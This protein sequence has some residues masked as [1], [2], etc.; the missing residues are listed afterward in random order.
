[1]FSFLVF[2]GFVAGP[3][4]ADL[5]EAGKCIQPDGQFVYGPE[6][7]AADVKA[8]ITIS[9]GHNIQIHS[10]TG[11]PLKKP[12]NQGGGVQTADPGPPVETPLGDLPGDLG[13]DVPGKNGKYKKST[14]IVSGNGTCVTI[15]GTRYCWHP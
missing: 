9:A 5:A 14:I 10:P 11:T 6:C 12:Q 13:K 1:M 4:G 7:F 8:I 3:W 2:S 15:N